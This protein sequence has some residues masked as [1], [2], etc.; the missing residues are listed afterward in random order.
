LSKEIN[1]PYLIKDTFKI[2]LC[3]NFPITNREDSSRFSAVTFDGMMYVTERLMEVGYPIIIEG[4]FVP[5]DMKKVNEA[6]VIKAL[7][8]KY[9]YQS[10][11]YKFM[12]DTKVLYERYIERDKLAERGDAN[13]DFEEVPY[14]RFSGYCH[15][16]E[17]FN[18]GGEVVK[19]DTT[20]F[21]RVD[22]AEYIEK[23][24][25]FIQTL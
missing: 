24:R 19:V 15:K 13:R 1:V 22:Y 6:G 2:A 8:D 17:K 20:D 7:I 12:G 11:T 9:N 23:A 3:D 14:E 25:L 21:S 18:V 5:P 10:L 16:L 4:N